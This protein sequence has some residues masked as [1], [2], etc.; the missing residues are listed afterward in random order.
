MLMKR[1][2]NV[3]DEST[4]QL[5]CCP[6]A[7]LCVFTGRWRFTDSHYHGAE[8]S[9]LLPPF[10]PPPSPLPPPVSQLQDRQSTIR[11][12]PTI[13]PSTT[14][15]G[16]KGKSKSIDPQTACMCLWVLQPLVGGPGLGQDDFTL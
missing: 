3:A 8:L 4:S 16:D 14:P 15:A 5:P 7:V 6:A 11:P 13:T 1:T 12:D 2:V 10:S 9:S